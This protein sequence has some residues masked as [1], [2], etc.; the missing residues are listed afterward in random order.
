MGKV[1]KGGREEMGMEGKGEE[2]VM[3]RSHPLELAIS[4]LG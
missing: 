1:K 4:S 3:Q 2:G